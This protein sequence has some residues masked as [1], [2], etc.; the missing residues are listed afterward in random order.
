MKQYIDKSVLVEKIEKR[1]KETESMDLNDQ[2]QAG[3]ISGFDSVLKL[4]DTLK[5]KMDKKIKEYEK[6]IHQ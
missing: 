2:F 3:Q 6:A 1:I 5:V 4:L